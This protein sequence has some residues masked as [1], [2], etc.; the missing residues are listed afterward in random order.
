MMIYG[1]ELLCISSVTWMKSKCSDLVHAKRCSKHLDSQ[2][3]A[4]LFLKT[5]PHCVVE[6]GFKLLCLTP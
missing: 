4:N 2:F 1:V 3:I 6:V 5:R